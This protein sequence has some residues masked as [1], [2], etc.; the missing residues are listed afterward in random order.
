MAWLTYADLV[1]Y[2]LEYLGSYDRATPEALRFVKLS[3]ESSLREILAEHDWS[4]LQ[5]DASIV[6]KA[7]YYTGTITYDSSNKQMTLTGGTWPTWAADGVVL[8]GD[9]WYDVQSRTS[10]TVIVMKDGPPESIATDT[11]YGIYQDTYDLPADFSV[12]QDIVAAD[13]WRS[14]VRKS[15]RELFEERQI[16]R[17]AG[18]PNYFSIYGSPNTPGRMS[19]RFSPVP[20]AEEEYPYLYKRAPKTPTIYKET[21]GTVTIANGSTTVTGLG[22]AFSQKHVGSILRVGKDQSS[23]PGSTSEEY[24]NVFEAKIVS[25]GGI[26]SLTV[27]AAPVE[28]LTTRSLCIS[29]PIDIDQTIMTSL[30]HRAICRRLA[31]DRKMDVNQRQLVDTDYG[32]ELLRAKG[33]DSRIKQPRNVGFRPAGFRRLKTG[34]NSFTG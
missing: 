23:F 24:P 1:R 30:I 15:P 6:T 29:D 11:A 17:S 32:N 2:G 3:I 13:R 33:A 25:V 14:I 18:Q 16:W 5:C 26:T 9:R 31:I 28:D 22:T 27:D 7:P 20:D 34:P 12:L 21:A 19:L 4:Y 8:I 10:N